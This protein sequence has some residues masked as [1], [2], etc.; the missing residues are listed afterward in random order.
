MNETRE[1]QRTVQESPTGVGAA[2]TDIRRTI[3]KGMVFGLMD[4]VRQ[5][6][7]TVQE[8]YKVSLLQR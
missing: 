1:D 4:D 5:D 3:R 8:S 7:R 6:H 2:E